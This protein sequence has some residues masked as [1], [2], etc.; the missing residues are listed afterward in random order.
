MLTPDELQ[1]LP[2]GINELY[3]ELNDFILKDISRRIAK[4]AKITETAEYQIY[5][6]QSLGLSN[7]DISDKITEINRISKE[8]VDKLYKEAAERSDMFDRK[9]LGKLQ[10]AGIPLSENYFLQQLV[11]AQAEQTAGLLENFTR[12]AGFVEYKS[13]KAVYTPLTDMYVKELDMAHLKIVSGAADYNSAIRATY[14]KLAAS[15]VRYINYKSGRSRELYSA[16]RQSVLDGTSKIAHKISEQNAALFG[17]DGWELSAH[18]GARPEHALYQGR[19]YPNSQYESIVEALINDYGCRHSAFPIIMGLSKPM[20]TDEELANIDPPPFT[21]EGQEYTAYEAAKEQ[22]HMESAMRRQKNIAVCAEAAGDEERFRTASI[23]LRRQREVYA[24]FSKKAGMFT[25]FERTQV[26]GYNKKLSAKA[27]AEVKQELDK[28]K[29]YVYNKSGTIRITDDWKEK[30]HVSIPQEYKPF[31]VIETMSNKSTSIQID[32]SYYD[33]N[34]K[35]QKQIHS[36]GHGNPSVHQFGKNNEHAH[37]FIWKN[38]QQQR[39]TR[40]LTKEER[41]ESGDIIE[42]D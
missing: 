42:S 13:G 33:E 16:V 4:G 19:Q 10:S 40:E 8:E 18:A 25:E 5:R 37:D 15:G 41:K 6:A 11:S 38:G 30:K 12:T 28:Y 26:Y 23:K 7:K 35:L 3:T 39:T 21:Y 22:R 31:A 27:G 29:K 34:A 20:Y 24:D 14:E 36:S 17:A 1:T 2:Q 9:V 32:R